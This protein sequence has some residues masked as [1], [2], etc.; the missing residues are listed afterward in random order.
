SFLQ[1]GLVT[2]FVSV[3]TFFGIMVALLVI[4]VQLALVVFVTLPPLYKRQ[5][6][7]VPATP[8][9]RFC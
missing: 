2:A 1:T 9:A 8:A 4:D 6:R 5:E 7:Y 3:V